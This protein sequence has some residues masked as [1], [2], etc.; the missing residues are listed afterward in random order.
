MLSI[1]GV[2]FA[3]SLVCAAQGPP[4]AGSFR[5][6][7]QW[8]E[9]PLINNPALNLTDAQRKQMQ[10]VTRDFRTR[11][12]DAR[13]ATDKAEG[14]LQDAFNDGT[15]DERRINDLIDRV[16]KARGE[17]LKLVTQMSWKLRTNLTADQ[18][19]QLQRQRPFGPEG[20]PGRGRSKRPPEG[21]PQQPAQGQTQPPKQ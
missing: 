1:A 20:V 15:S 11:Q 3:A 19:Q 18:W 14:D 12:V 16:V 10:T 2:L 7:R 4:G 8:W 13:A 5:G 9:N 6:G 21:A 17:M